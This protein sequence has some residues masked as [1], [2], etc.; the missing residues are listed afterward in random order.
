MTVNLNTELDVMT[1]LQKLGQLFVVEHTLDS[2]LLEIVDTAIEIAGADFG[3]IQLVDALSG[4]LYIA[5]QRG[6]PQWWLDYWNTTSKGRGACGT[7]LLRNERVVIEDVDTSPVFAGSESLDI[8]RRAGVRAVQS[9]PLLSRSGQVLGMFSTHYQRPYR[10]DDRCL[11]LLDLLARQ[12]ADMIDRANAD[13]EQRHRNAAERET[14]NSRLLSSEAQLRHLLHRIDVQREEERK[15][16]SLELHDDVGQCL[17]AINLQLRLL[18]SQMSGDDA[19]DRLLDDV[20]GT[21]RRTIHGVRDI[22]KSL[23]PPEID[24]SFTASIAELVR[25]SPLPPQATVQLDLDEQLDAIAST[26]RLVAYRVVQE[27][28]SN[29]AKHADAKLVSITLRMEDDG[30]VIN[31][32][33]DGHGFDLRHTRKGGIGLA[34]MSE[35][36]RATNGQLQINSAPGNGTSIRCR[37]PLPH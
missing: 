31:V 19:Q 15:H 25:R 32:E 1:R 22:S 4:D 36:V 24:V 13:V 28:L 34:G 11:V 33:D 23:R 12:A 7:A 30:L 6:F 2:V 14:L 35:R 37:L 18:K 21:L 20:L 26:I 17:S 16:L 5:A 9:T 3:N 27:S 10:P 8:Q 29:V